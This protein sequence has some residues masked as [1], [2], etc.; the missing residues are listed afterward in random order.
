MTIWWGPYQLSPSFIASHPRAL[1]P[2]VHSG[3]TLG[4]F[5]LPPS[6][7]HFVNAV[8]ERQEEKHHDVE[9]FFVVFLIIS[10]LHNPRIFADDKY[11]NW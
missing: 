8:D 2:T 1:F 4:Q 3:F 9:F 7:S 6:A 11:P 10:P 5:A